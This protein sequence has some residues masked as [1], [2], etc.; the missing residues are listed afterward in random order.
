MFQ[1]IKAQWPNLQSLLNQE[2][3]IFSRTPKDSCGCCFVWMWGEL[4]IF[5]VVL[6][7]QRFIMYPWLAKDLL[8]RLD[9]DGFELTKFCVTVPFKSWA[10]RSASP[11]PGDCC[12]CFYLFKRIYMYNF[13]F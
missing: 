13:K 3:D 11:H 10:H 6:G 12:F 4:F 7:E 5:I 9:Q 8:C 2:L 1:L